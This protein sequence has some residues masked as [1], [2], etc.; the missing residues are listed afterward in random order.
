LQNPLLRPHPKLFRHL[1]LQRLKLPKQNLL[2]LLFVAPMRSLPLPLS[3]QL[4]KNPP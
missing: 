2:L 3:P 1:P 4:L